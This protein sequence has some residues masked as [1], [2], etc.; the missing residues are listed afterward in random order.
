MIKP[1]SQ[2]KNKETFINNK[3]QEKNPSIGSCH[4]NSSNHS[5]T[6]SKKGT[7]SSKTGDLNKQ[8][9]FVNK[10]IS[11]HFNNSLKSVQTTFA[12]QIQQLEKMLMGRVL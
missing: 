7:P 8:S 3:S 10:D 9:T 11:T 5:K 2:D 4:H 1:R 12:M 6:V